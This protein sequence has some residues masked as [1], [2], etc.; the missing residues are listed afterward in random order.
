VQ[1]KLEEAR[2]AAQRGTALSL[3]SS[4]PVLKLPAEIAQARV[5]MKG[6]SAH[7]AAAQRRLNSV[8]ATARRLGYYHL[9]SQ[10][11]LALGELEI[12]INAPLARKHLTRLASEVRIHGFELLARQAEDVAGK[13]AVIAENGATH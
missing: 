5:E 9:E 8:V 13:G 7:L 10:A 11:R 12:Q 1:G 6:T 3:T 2:K 4:D